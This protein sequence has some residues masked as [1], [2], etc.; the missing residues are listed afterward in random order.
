LRIEQRA[1]PLTQAA[2]VFANILQEELTD[3]LKI[4]PVSRA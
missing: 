1:K 4:P 3:A 2:Q